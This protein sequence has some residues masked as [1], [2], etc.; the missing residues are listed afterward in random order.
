MAEWWRSITDKIGKLSDSEAVAPPATLRER[1]EREKEKLKME[2]EQS[3]HGAVEARAPGETREDAEVQDRRVLIA[4]L[5]WKLDA[6]FEPGKHPTSN[7][8]KVDGYW[9]GV[10]RYWQPARKAGEYDQIGWKLF[11]HRVCPHCKALVPTIELG[12]YAEVGE[13]TARSMVGEDVEVPKSTA[14][15]AAYLNDLEAGRPD[16]YCPRQCPACRKLIK[17]GTL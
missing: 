16:M 17:G 12:D 6:R 3:R 13:A 14:R 4:L 1:L 9:F 8:S 11:F 15:L 5:G 2:S 7:P 10:R